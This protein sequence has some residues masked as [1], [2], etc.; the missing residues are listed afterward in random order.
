MLIVQFQE[1]L[2]LSYKNPEAHYLKEIQIK[3]NFLTNQLFYFNAIILTKESMANTN[4]SLVSKNFSLDLFPSAYNVLNIQQ[5]LVSVF[6]GL[7]YGR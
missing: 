6:Y 2:L 3:Y 7:S 1:L 5:Q 4:W